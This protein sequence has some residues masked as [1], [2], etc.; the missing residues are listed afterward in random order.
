MSDMIATVARSHYIE[1][2]AR[3]TLKFN[4]RPPQFNRF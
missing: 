4:P 2:L 1:Q 3:A